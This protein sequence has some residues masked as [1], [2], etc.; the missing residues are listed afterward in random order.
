MAALV[1]RAGVPARSQS[2]AIDTI[3]KDQAVHAEPLPSAQ[4]E[5]MMEQLTVERLKVRRDWYKGLA[6]DPIDHSHPDVGDGDEPPAAAQR[7]GL[8]VCT[9]LP[10]RPLA[11][12]LLSV[13]VGM[14]PGLGA[15]KARQR[16]RVDT[17][18]WW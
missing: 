7:V 18:G 9:T 8:Q 4:G 11:P 12:R 6:A 13:L 5:S 10:L 3:S 16:L 17:S 1:S 2:R 14:A 15:C